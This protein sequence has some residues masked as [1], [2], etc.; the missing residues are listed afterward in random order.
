MENSQVAHYWANQLKQ[1]ASGSHFYFNGA[2][3]YSYG[4]H[5]PIARHIEFDGEKAV[6]FT[7]QKYSPTTQRHISIALH[8]CSHLNV[9]YCFSPD[10][11]H[12]QNFA[13]WLTETNKYIDL[14]SRCRKPAKH[15]LSILDIKDRVIKYCEF[16][17]IDM[18]SALSKAFDIINDPKYAEY[19]Q[20][21]ERLQSYMYNSRL[22][23]SQINH[24]KA[25]E[26]WLAGKR[27]KIYTRFDRDYLREKGDFIETTQGV[28]IPL[29]EAKRFWRALVYGNLHVGDKI[30]GYAVSELNGDRVKIGCH[31]FP[32]EYLL[33]FGKEHFTTKKV[34]D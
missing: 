19:P 9:V 15:L 18:P 24:E 16:F 26:N 25:L 11:S 14:L 17:K 27:D 30:Q 23:I 22:N 7:E 1:S 20:D 4:P 5:F 34:S 32:Y 2:T 13:N 33:N 29:D 3:I 12:E 6:L 8:A 31:T 10:S 21:T 28:K